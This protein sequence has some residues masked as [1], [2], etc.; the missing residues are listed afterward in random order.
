MHIPDQ[1]MPVFVPCLLGYAACSETFHAATNDCDWK[2]FG[3]EKS[4]DTLKQIQI[5]NVNLL[6]YETFLTSTDDSDWKIPIA[7]WPTSSVDQ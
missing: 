4:R 3:E 6:R 5:L 7:S 1:L 2:I